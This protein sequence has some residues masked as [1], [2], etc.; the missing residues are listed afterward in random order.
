M[1]IMQKSQQGF[2]LI[3]L[4]I[5]IVILGILAA[6]ALPKFVD[7]KSDA[8]LAAVQGV[9]GSAAAGS[10]TN[11]AAHLVGKPTAVNVNSTNVCDDA[12]I[13]QLLNGGL[14]A[15]YT[16]STQSVPGNCSVATTDSVQC[17]MNKGS[18]NAQFT[19]LC[20]H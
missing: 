19:V 6:V 3:E 10:V 4:V 12:T 7:L 16:V 20:T 5:V 18:V 9:A 17:Q 11:Y 14:P 2:T 13:G 1:N 15:G 8:E